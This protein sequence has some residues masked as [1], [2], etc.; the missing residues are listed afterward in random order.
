MTKRRPPTAGTF[1]WLAAVSAVACAVLPDIV[2]LT[3]V[4]GPHPSRDRVAV[5]SSPGPRVMGSLHTAADAETA[6][7]RF[8]FAAGTP[9]ADEVAEQPA[10]F[11]RRLEPAEHALDL[12]P[13]RI[14]PAPQSIA[15]DLSTPGNVERSEA[16]A[17]ASDEAGTARPDAEASTNERREPAGA[18]PSDAE[19]APAAAVAADDAKPASEAA[20]VPPAA[21]SALLETSAVSAPVQRPEADKPVDRK[22]AAETQPT[23][24]QLEPKQA[25]KRAIAG[26]QVGKRRSA[27]A[28]DGEAPAPK[29]KWRPEN[30]NNWP[31]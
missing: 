4:T 6:I 18:S 1:A 25:S 26:P 17:A 12:P 14:A 16:A 31:D 29:A 23:K 30:L 11:G 21:P 8:R 5:S 13:D 27:A 9:F 20:T 15:R 7:D 2:D 24:R 22:P 28:D 10:A 19:Y 3:N